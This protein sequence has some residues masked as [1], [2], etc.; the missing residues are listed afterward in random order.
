MPRASSYYQTE[1][2]CKGPDSQGA[3]RLNQLPE[4]I[5]FI[6]DFNNPGVVF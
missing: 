3:T 5:I 1:K 2:K 4:M 6:V